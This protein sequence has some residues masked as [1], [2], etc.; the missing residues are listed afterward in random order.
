[1]GCA[2]ALGCAK[3]GE[4]E[5]C[6]L[7]NADQDCEPGLVCRGEAQLS[8]K[9]RGIALCCPIGTGSTVDAC[10]AG[11][12]LPP[13]PDAGL[14]PEPPPPDAAAAPES[15]TDAAADAAP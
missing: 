11:T 4:G 13:E 3:Q 2:L 5:R 12:Q 9:G 14:T 7:N 8:I 15:P 6:D 1:M 10:R